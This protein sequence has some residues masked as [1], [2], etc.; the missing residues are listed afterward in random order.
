MKKYFQI[1]TLLALLLSFVPANASALVAAPAVDMFQLPWEQ[2]L[3]WVAFDGLD[4][5]SRRSSNSPHNYRNGGAVDFAPRVDMYVGMD[6]SNF[7]V[8]AA[9]AGTVYEISSCHIKINHGN[10]WTTE[11]WHLDNIQVSLGSNVSRNQR[12]GIL[13]NN[14][15]QQVCVGN[16][17]PGPHLHFVMRPVLR[18]TI[19]AGW[20]VNYNIFTNITTFT[21]NGLTVGR[22]QPILNVPNLQIASRGPLNWDTQYAGTVDPY[23]HE[24]W[25]LSLTEQTT[26]HVTANPVT[27][28]LATAI[29]LLDSSGNEIT[30]ANG[31]LNSTQPA[32]NYFVQIQSDFGTGFYNIIATR[33]ASPGPTPTPTV[34]GTP[35]TATPTV[36]GTLPTATPTVTGTPPTETPTVTGTPPTA[37]PTLTG[38]PPTATPSAT[39]TPIFTNTPLVTDTPS[40]T[41]TPILTNTP[42]QTSTPLFTETPV[43]TSTPLAT[44]TPVVTFTPLASETPIFTNT[45]VATSTLLASETPSLT[46]TPLPTFTPLATNTP[47]VTD[48]PFVITETPIFTNTPIPTQTASVPTSTDTPIPSATPT[49][50]ATFTATTIIPTATNT[51]LPTGPYVLTSANP[52][53]ILIG[54]TSLVTVSLNNVPAEG[55]RSTEFTCTYNPTLV[56]VSNIAIAG[57]FGPDPVSAINGPQNGSFILAIAGSN[58]NRATTSGA[59][60]TFN[61]RG[62]QAGQSPLECRARVSRGDSTLES[63]L[64]I[65]DTLTIFDSFPTPTATQI[66]PPVLTGQV[67]AS[68]PVTIRLFNADSTLAATTTANVD[69][70][71]MLTAPSGNYTV[72]ASALG[73]LNAQGPA[74]LVNG[75]TTTMPLVSLP[76]GDIDGNG[77]I[78]QFDALTIGMNYNASFPAAADLNNDGII[79]VLDLELLA[80]NYRKSGALIWQ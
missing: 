52:Q 30:R 63:I 60:F 37:T 51:A 2:G 74:V 31:V 43:I 49:A 38:T 64:Y 67:F 80:A 20:Q 16:E 8:T 19:F 57:L 54:A 5:G 17:F 1:F 46:D 11:Y 68:K 77:V 40:I 66:S 58:G 76:A 41:D 21:K 12:L 61:A 39:E 59:A 71:F 48:T 4:N 70:T 79:N 22:L 45:P 35:P 62:L 75:M 55:Y 13:D 23:R 24:R 14:Q 65:P 18:D 32:G 33:D 27:S 53:S 6:T 7:W 42:I 29:V 3:A 56:E 34:T 9:A 15:D 47:L 78:D 10:G 25:T 50:M 28:G 69:G 73:F 26:F 72:V 36:T 44:E